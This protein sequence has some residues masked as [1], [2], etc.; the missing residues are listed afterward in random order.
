MPRY[1]V[2]DAV[3]AAVGGD[4][5]LRPSGIERVASLPRKQLAA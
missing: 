2:D 1:A 5:E 4:D 3:A